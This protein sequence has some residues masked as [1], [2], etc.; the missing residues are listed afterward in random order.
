MTLENVVQ[1]R[2]CFIVHGPTR[3]LL[4]LSGFSELAEP[5]ATVLVWPKRKILSVLQRIKSFSALILHW[6]QPQA[7]R[8][9]C[10]LVKVILTAVV[11]YKPQ[12]SEA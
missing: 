4:M 10:V 8:C 6:G 5:R 12:I 1:V 3:V 11:T 7:Y 9:N 2:G